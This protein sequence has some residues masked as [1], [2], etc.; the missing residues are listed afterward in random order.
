MHRSPI[1]TER[2]SG[3]VKPPP[4]NSSGGFGAPCFRS[5]HFSGLGSMGP[6]AVARIAYPI[7]SESEYRNLHRPSGCRQLQD[8]WQQQTRYAIFEPARRTTDMSAPGI[9]HPHQIHDNSGLCQSHAL[10][11]SALRSNCSCMQLFTMQC[12]T[13]L[14][15]IPKKW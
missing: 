5:S 13:R 3:T 11:R 7:Q 6:F 2:A 8:I 15:Q 1:E 14:I 9:L 10:S 4:H 12:Y